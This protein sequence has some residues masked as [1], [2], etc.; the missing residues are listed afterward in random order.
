MYLIGAIWLCGLYETNFYKFYG[1]LEEIG[2]LYV[3]SVFY[4]LYKFGLEVLLR[5][6][7]KCNIK[8]IKYYLIFIKTAVAFCGK[9]RDN[10]TVLPIH[11]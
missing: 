3:M 5:I 8:K 6:F 1:R 10:F 4:L 9:M 7:A 2:L 11:L